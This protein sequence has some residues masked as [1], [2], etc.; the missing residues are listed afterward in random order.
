VAP[1]YGN[2]GVALE[3]TGKYGELLKMHTKS[4]EIDFL[5]HGDNH[6]D[7][8]AST[9]NTGLVLKAMGKKSEAKQMSTE[10]VVGHKV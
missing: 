10:A 6:S 1:S 3:K 5:V 9:E 4:L 8:M 2:M 7:V